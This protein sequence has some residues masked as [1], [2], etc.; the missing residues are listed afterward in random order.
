MVDLAFQSTLIELPDSHD[1]ALELAAEPRTTPRL[2]RTCRT[3]EGPPDESCDE[4]QA[5]IC[6]ACDERCALCEAVLCD[7]CAARH[8]HYSGLVPEP[9]VRGCRPAAACATHRAC[10]THAPLAETC[11]SAPHY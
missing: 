7:P 5:P 1:A 6:V 11:G 2:A 10:S 4:C 9:D 3:C 8:V